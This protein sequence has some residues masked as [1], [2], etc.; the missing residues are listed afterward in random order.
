MTFHFSALA[1]A[2]AALGLVALAGC[3][4]QRISELQPGVSTEADVRDRFGAPE[5]IWDE[6]DGARTLEYNRQP[7]GQINYMITVGADGRL[8]AVRQVLTAE[9]FARITPGMDMALVRR[10]LGK[11]AKVIPYRLSGET[12]HDWRFIEPPNVPKVFTV[13]TKDGS[14]VLRTQIGPDMDAP[15]NKGGR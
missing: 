2:A 9:N 13:V 6:A 11:P 14:T 8:V 12:H 7:A 10:S 3:D 5:T 4:A 1:F 15:E